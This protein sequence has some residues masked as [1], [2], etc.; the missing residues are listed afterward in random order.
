M[1]FFQVSVLGAVIR[2]MVQEIRTR[3]V[4]LTPLS[5]VV[6]EIGFV[7]IPSKVVCCG[8][9]ENIL[10]DTQ[11]LARTSQA[12]PCSRFIAGSVGCCTKEG[13]VLAEEGRKEVLAAAALQVRGGVA[14]ME[15]FA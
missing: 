11:R 15:R 7:V 13:Q 3:L 6:K 12:A 4:P 1:L 5:D 2:Y 14:R 8:D 9:R 10:P